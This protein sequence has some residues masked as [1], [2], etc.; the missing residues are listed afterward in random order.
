[1]FNQASNL[2]IFKKK[3]KKNLKIKNILRE[4]S[5]YLITNKMPDL[6]LLSTNLKNTE[7][8]CGTKVAQ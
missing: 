6:N 7:Y 4:N 8:A 1:M 5:E 2:K 3:M